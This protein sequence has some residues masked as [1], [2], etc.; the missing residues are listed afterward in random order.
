MGMHTIFGQLLVQ[1][2][3]M[4]ITHV[5]VITLL[6]SWCFNAVDAKLEMGHQ[7]FLVHEYLTAPW[8][9]V[10]ELPVWYLERGYKEM[11]S[12][13]GHVRSCVVPGERIQGDGQPEGTC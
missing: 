9:S 7:V 8:T 1:Y 13:R 5:I 12:R 2:T 6:V 11:G 3:V 10:L 4:Y